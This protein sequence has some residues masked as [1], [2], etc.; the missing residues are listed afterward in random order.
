MPWGS[1]GSF[2]DALEACLADKGGPGSV[3]VSQGS[4][5]G[6]AREDDGALS[7]ARTQ[8]PESTLQPTGDAWEGHNVFLGRFWQSLADL[9]AKYVVFVWEMQPFDVPNLLAKMSPRNVAQGI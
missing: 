8:S 9:P 2:V 3:V 5:R 6:V 1:L 4:H 7:V